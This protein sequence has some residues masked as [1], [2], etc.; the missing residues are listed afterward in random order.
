M[1]KDDGIGCYCDGCEKLIEGNA[2]VAYSTKPS[3]EAV[4]CPEI[5][6]KTFITHNEVCLLLVRAKRNNLNYKCPKCNGQG[7]K[8]VDELLLNINE[9]KQQLVFASELYSKPNRYQG[10]MESIKKITKSCDLCLGAGFLEKEPIPV[11]T[12]WKRG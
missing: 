6:A 9:N 12:N 8:F 2:F 10:S 1:N 7:S 11:I 4:G 3:S 5:I